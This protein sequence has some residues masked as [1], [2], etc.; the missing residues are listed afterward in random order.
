MTATFLIS[1]GRFFADS[2]LKITLAHLVLNY[3][4]RMANER[5]GRPR[6]FYVNV[7]GVCPEANILVKRR[8]A[9]TQRT[10]PAGEPLTP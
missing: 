3:D 7:A 6:T 9:N 2:Q 10:L 8:G 5:A 1:P 4:L